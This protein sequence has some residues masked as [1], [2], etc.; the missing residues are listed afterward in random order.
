MTDPKAMLGDLSATQYRTLIE[1]TS[2]VIAVVDDEGTILFQSANSEHVK[3]WPRGDLL[4]ENI[5][6]YI[7]PDD[8]DR[9][10][11]QFSKPQGEIGV[12]DDEIEFRFRKKDGEYTW[13]ASTGTAP[14][15]DSPIDGY[16]TTS[17]DV[18]D[19]KEYEQ[20]LTEQ[21]DDLGI[22]NGILRHDIRNDLQ[23]IQSYADLIGE[24]VDGDIADDLGVIKE[25][26]GNA[27]ALTETTGD[28]TE[29]MLGPEREPERV[30]LRDS[31]GA[32][33]DAV[34]ASYPD[35]SVTLA[36]SIPET[37]VLADELLDSVF[38]NLLKNAIQHND[39]GVPDVTVEA[40]TERGFCVVR[41]ADNG[42]GIPD[43]QKEEIFGKSE[44]G[45]E[46]SGTGVGLY[47]VR[48]LLESYGGGVRVEDN[49]PVGS[50]FVVRVPIAE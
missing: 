31:L 47:L 17:R 10:V 15:T 13:L 29:V 26:V 27:I 49:E 30:S 9:V 5:V 2:D 42:P 33:F 44:K 45:L 34:R 16:V 11:E 39:K 20:R 43:D 14:G 32:E 21:R 3:G 7:H 8:R 4:G 38:R 46:S 40:G 48:S 12:I 6:E 24:Q 37:D 41:I 22:I 36:G 35:A 18:S 23:L 19:R 50:V 1:Q 28:L 25:S